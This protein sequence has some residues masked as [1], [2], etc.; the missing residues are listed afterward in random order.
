MKA[1]RC[2]NIS[3]V[4]MSF[5][6]CWVYQALTSFPLSIASADDSPRTIP[7]GLGKIAELDDEE[8]ALNLSLVSQLSSWISVSVSR[9]HSLSRWSD[10][11][12]QTSE[13]QDVICGVTP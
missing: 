6:G 9:A 7:G 10:S 13:W 2:T 12:N 5:V 8:R 4:Y 1:T 3:E 11:L